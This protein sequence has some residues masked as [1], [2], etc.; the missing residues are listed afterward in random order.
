[1]RRGRGQGI[2]TGREMW[3]DDRGQPQDVCLFWVVQ[4]RSLANP[5]SLAV[6]VRM[7]PSIRTIAGRRSQLRNDENRWRADIS[8]GVTTPVSCSRNKFH[9]QSV[10]DTRHP[11]R[12]MKRSGA[13]DRGLRKSAAEEKDAQLSEFL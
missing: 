5:R 2:I 3:P 7:E 4:R 9:L 11:T 8:R 13:M 12:S 6:S 1:M 10:N